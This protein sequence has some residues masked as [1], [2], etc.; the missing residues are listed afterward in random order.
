MVTQAPTGK[1]PPSAFAA[2]ITSGLTASCSWAHSEPVR[3]MPGLDLVE[4]K[5]RPRLVAGLARG[6][7]HL[8]GD[9]EDARLALD[10][11]DQDGRGGGA[12]RRRATRPASSRG[13]ATKPC[14]QRP[15]EVLSREARGR[16]ERAQRAAV[17]AAA[18]APR[19]QAARCPGRGRAFGPASA[20]T[21]SP[22]CPSC[23]GTPCRP[24]LDSTRRSQ[25]RIAGSE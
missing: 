13:T 18:R 24:R 9:R 23:K 17:E 14:R 21:R 3:P 19:P 11:L 16:G 15:E 4:D 22:R 2:V 6:Q 20:R 12:D 7:E 25:R 1:P 10:R 8:V 5:Q